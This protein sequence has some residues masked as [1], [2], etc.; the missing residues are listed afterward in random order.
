MCFCY[1]RVEAGGLYSDGTLLRYVLHAYLILINEWMEDLVK[2]C[3]QIDHVGWSGWVGWGCV[4]VGV[5][6]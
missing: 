2:H 4:G 1:G 5:N 3:I 6:R